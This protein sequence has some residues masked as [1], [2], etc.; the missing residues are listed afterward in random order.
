MGSM[1]VNEAVAVLRSPIKR[2]G[3]WMEL[4]GARV[5]EEDQRME[6]ME[7]MM[8]VMELSEEIDDATTQEQIDKLSGQHD[9]KISAVE[10][11]LDGIFQKQDWDGARKFVERLQMLVRLRERMN[12]WQ[13][14]R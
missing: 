7:T 3:Y 6:D 8:E 9:E 4:N 5:L 1:R 2:A 11:R 10:Q 13:P 12:D 14:P